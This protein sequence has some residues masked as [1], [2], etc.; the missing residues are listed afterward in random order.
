M[1]WGTPLLAVGLAHGSQAGACALHATTLPRARICRAAPPLMMAA[2]DGKK[3]G[4]GSAVSFPLP[5][6]QQQV[7]AGQQPTEEMR[8][9]RRQPFMEW[10]DDDEYGGR[11]QSLYL[12]IS[13]FLSLPI[14]YTTY[15]VLPNELPQLFLAANL[16]T[17]AT[18]VP[19]ITRLR[20][21]WS[22]VSKRLRSRS[23]YY[24][25][26]QAG[27]LAKKDKGTQMR[28]KLV[29][30]EQVA[31]VLRRIN[32]SL[33]SVLTALFLSLVGAEALTIYQ[34]DAGPV[35]LKTLT[36]EEAKRFENRLKGDDDFARREQQ[37]AQSRAGPEGELQPV[38]CNSRYYKILAG[39]NGQGGVGCGGSY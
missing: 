15:Y 38:Y 8:N 22:A 16:G 34:G 7:P 4:G 20:F 5:F 30:K 9:L 19:F 18:M 33:F 6:F 2:D 39:G 14:A 37:R 24:E 25:A 1:L 13:L 11:L 12:G 10:A 32:A 23:I 35:T 36:G 21:G 28:D 17:L 29:E 31:P 3:A 26:E 27:L